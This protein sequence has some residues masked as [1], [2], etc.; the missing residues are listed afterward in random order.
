M[1]VNI[2]YIWDI[3]EKKNS[4]PQDFMKLSKIVSQIK[5]AAKSFNININSL[6]I[7]AKK[8]DCTSINAK[9]NF[10]FLWAFHIYMQTLI[11]M[12][13]LGNK[14]RLQLALSEDVYHLTMLWEI[15]TWKSVREYH[16]DF[17][18]A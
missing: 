6:D 1:S 15:Y 16:F 7:E 2:Q 5:K 12:A 13:T 10:F 4:K 11:F 9:S 14:L 18:P 3:Q 8:R 17:H